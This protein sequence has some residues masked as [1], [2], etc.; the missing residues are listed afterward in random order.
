MSAISTPT[1]GSQSRSPK[2]TP[3]RRIPAASGRL[4]WKLVIFAWKYVIGT[5]FG[6][7]LFLAAATPEGLV[8]RIL[9]RMILAPLI[10]VVVVGWTYRLMQRSGLKR[11]WKLA[12][13]IDHR[14]ETFA[15][16]VEGESATS[17]HRHWPNWFVPQNVRRWIAEP[18]SVLGVC[19][20]LLTAPLRGLWQN[21]KLG[22]QGVFN[23][24]VL[25]MPACGLWLFSWY[26]GWNNSFH[27]GYEQFWVGPLTG[28]LGVLLF[29]AAMTYV[30][31][32]QARQAVSGDWRSF[33]DFRFVRALVRRRW[34]PCMLLALCYALASLPVMV[35]RILP[36]FQEQAS[37]PLFQGR[38]TPAEMIQA[39]NEYTWIA[40]AILLPLFVGLHWAAARIYATAVFRA[41]RSGEVPWEQ[42]GA[43]EQ[44][45]LQRLDVS[46]PVSK[47]R[48]PLAVKAVGWTGGWI[49]RLAAG[50]VAAALW[51]A[52]V[53]EIFIAEFFNYHPVLGWLNQPLVQLPWL[54]Y[55]PLHLF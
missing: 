50:T 2:P 7:G 45:A 44:S 17:G 41:V 12:G 19:W 10:S 55:V 37:I 1:V 48:R 18:G 43:F 47:P 3:R 16:F 22:L 33:Y 31:L 9:L 4:G 40:S 53:A 20:R 13:R 49:L 23:T 34:L 39:L 24:W 6:C 42:L 14:P 36:A 29:M 46:E 51:F 35:L 21:A 15:E 26:A 52:F 30:P 8:P 11:W 54:H 27:K 32:A 5:L 28:W 25:T 38:E